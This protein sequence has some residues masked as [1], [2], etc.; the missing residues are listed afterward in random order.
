MG[1]ELSEQF[2]KAYRY[3]TSCDPEDVAVS[4]IVSAEIRL[5]NNRS[6]TILNVRGSKHPFIMRGKIDELMHN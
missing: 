5:Y 4:Q 2:V 3:L 1:T 6:Y